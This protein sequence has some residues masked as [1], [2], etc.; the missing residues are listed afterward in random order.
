MRHMLHGEYL[1]ILFGSGTVRPEARIDLKR[2]NFKVMQS[3]CTFSQQN[4]WELQL[5][6]DLLWTFESFYP[7]LALTFWLVNLTTKRNS[8]FP[9]KWACQSHPTRWKVYFFQQRLLRFL[10]HAGMLLDYKK[11][12]IGLGDS[13]DSKYW[14]RQL[15]YLYQIKNC[16]ELHEIW[17]FKENLSKPSISEAL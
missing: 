9:I 17:F 12:P 1:S 8:G 14:K 15:T 4:Y 5:R 13:R 6:S 7:L 10:L 16:L 3:V 2:K 11:N